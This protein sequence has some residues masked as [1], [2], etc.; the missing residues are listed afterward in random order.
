MRIALTP[1]GSAVGA[2]LLLMSAAAC[3]ASQTKA[4][5]PVVV[6]GDAGVDAS[7]AAVERP[8]ASTPLEAQ[9]MIQALIDARM[10]VLWK[11]VESYRTRI[12]DP[13]RGVTVNVGI[14]QEGH[15]F[16]VTAPDPK[17][18]DLEPALKACVLETLRDAPF[19]RSHTGVITVRQVFQDTAVSR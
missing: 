15:L 1:R 3:G 13:H 8:F 5:E 18:A 4:S 10:K 6:I 9:T 12:G 16:G 7:G 17:H 2:S 14:D 19:P 11:C